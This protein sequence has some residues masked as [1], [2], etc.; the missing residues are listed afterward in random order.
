M[1]AT[2]TGSVVQT[3][4]QFINDN[5]IWSFETN[6]NDRKDILMS[7]QHVPLCARSFHFPKWPSLK[8]AV[9]HIKS[10]I[11]VSAIFE[12]MLTLSMTNMVQPFMIW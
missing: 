9:L 6:I 11:M 10:L 8:S 3:S 2:I 1:C 4:R 5:S 12:P 7:S